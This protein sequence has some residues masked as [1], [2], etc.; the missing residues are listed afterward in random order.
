MVAAREIVAETHRRVR[1]DEHGAGVDEVLRARIRH[2]QF[3]VLGRVRVAERGRGG[4]IVDQDDRRLGTRQGDGHA[5]R[6]PRARCADRDFAGHGLGERLRIG[7]EHGRGLLVV[8]GLADQIGGDQARVRCGVRDDEDLG[9]AGLGIRPDHTRDGALGGRDEV[10]ARTADDIDG[11]E[12]DAGDAVREGADRA[13]A[14]H[15]VHLGD[16][17]EPRRGQDHGVHP[18]VVLT[19]RRRGERHFD[20]TRDLGG[21]DVHD[22]ARRVDRLAARDVHADPAHRLPPLPDARAGAELG[23]GGRGHLGGGR[24]AHPID[25]LFQGGPHG[26]VQ[27][28]ERFVQVRCGHAQVVSDGTVEALGLGAQCGLAV[29]GDVGDEARCGGQRFLA[30]GGGARNGR[31]QFGGRKRAAAQINGAEHP[32]TLSRAGAPGPRI[33]PE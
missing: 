10:V 31:Q 21:H 33:S 7:H 27:P 28:G 1:A 23:Q 18:A 11:V 5:L 25:G 6:V 9:G 14:A 15:G 26:R 3:E 19:L 16:A 4:Q 12:I 17:E 30:G 29:P 2:L 24:R 32:I 20:D 22:D 13:G 8:L